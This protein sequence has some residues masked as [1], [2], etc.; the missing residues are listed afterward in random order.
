MCY[1]DCFIVLSVFL[2]Y[3][4]F[5]ICVSC[6]LYYNISFLNSPSIH[7]SPQIV[8]LINICISFILSLPPPPAC[9][10]HPPL[11]SRCL[12]RLKSGLVALGRVVQI[13]AQSHLLTSALVSV[14]GS[15]LNPALHLVLG[16]SLVLLGVQ[17][18][19]TVLVCWPF[20]QT[21][22]GRI[23]SKACVLRMCLF[24]HIVLQHTLITGTFFRTQ[25][26]TASQYSS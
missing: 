8:L 20:K 19:Y 14:L 24:Y 3:Q 12:R 6:I 2:L 7:F 15:P 13:G 18:R 4:P 10:S 11:S 22:K 17:A 9:P 25:T 23:Y 26:H 5:Y 1:C 21:V 16:L